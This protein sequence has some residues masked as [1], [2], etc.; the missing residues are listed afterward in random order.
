LPTY[1]HP[2]LLPFLLRGSHT[3]FHL[4]PAAAATG[5]PPSI[6]I[7]GAGPLK[8]VIAQVYQTAAGTADGPNRRKAT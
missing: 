7:G 4:V 5:E 8:I 1:L 6:V 3:V 2:I